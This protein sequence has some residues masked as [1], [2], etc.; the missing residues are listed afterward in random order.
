MV[1]LNQEI[2]WIPEHIRDGQFGKLARGRARLVD[3]PQPLLGLADPRLEERRSELSAHRRLRQPRRARARLR[4][5][6][7]RSAPPGD[8]RAH[9]TRTPTIPTG[10]ST[11]RRVEEVL[12]CWFESG[13][14]P[15]AQVHYPFENKEWFEKHF[16]ADFIT[17]YVAQTRGWFYT[18]MVLSTALFDRPPFQ[19]L[20]LPR[21]GG[22]RHGKQALEAP[23]QLP[24]ARGLSSIR[25][26]RT[27]CAGSCAA[28]PDHA[29]PATCSIDA[30]A[31]A[32]AEAVRLVLNPIWNA[33][34]LLLPLRERRRR[35]RPIP[36]ATRYGPARPLRPGQDARAG[37]RDR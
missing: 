25:T 9:A 14:M 5:A 30:R 3:Q 34:S 15:Y 11:M 20:H 32:I 13:S 6:P 19:Q 31:R 26:A 33:Y 1:E 29:R 18:M 7:Q 37:G 10:K 27:R 28:P 23:A 4:R 12:D 2:R 22:R 17:E 35:A 21:H 16:P 36:H 8:R 24:R